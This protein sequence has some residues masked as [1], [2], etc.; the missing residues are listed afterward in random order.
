MSAAL[1]QVVPRRDFS[2][3]VLGQ[4]GR[5]FSEARTGEHNGLRI[6]LGGA[7]NVV[8][9]G[10]L[11]QGEEGI[12]RAYGLEW[13]Q[14]QVRYQLEGWTDEALAYCKSALASRY[15]SFGACCHKMELEARE[16]A[17]V[18]RGPTQWIL[19]LQE[20]RQSIQTFVQQELGLQAAVEL[21]EN[22][23]EEEAFEQQRRMQLEKACQ[24]AAQQVPAQPALGTPKAP[25]REKAPR[26]FERRKPE[27]TV[28]KPKNSEQKV[29][30]GK[31][32]ERVVIKMAEVNVD[33]GKV[34]VEGEVFYTE[35]KKLNN[36][37]KTI[38]TFDMTD[39]TGS[40]RC[41]KVLPDEEC[42]LLMEAVKKGSYVMVQ[43]V[44]NYSTFE[45]DVVVSPTAVVEAKKKLRQD[46]AEQKRVE[47]HLH[48]CMSTMDGLATAGDLIQTA[49]RWG[50][51]AVA[52]T[53]HGVVQSFPMVGN[54]HCLVPP[55]GRRLDQ[56]PG[57][58]QA[59]HGGHAGM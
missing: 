5:G 57:G 55:P 22:Q 32:V 28:Y 44:A 11:R 59:I 3:S 33:S 24:Q 6:G 12:C 23:G 38:Y 43:G 58:R 42:A 18:L 36:R 54:G 53:D 56:I 40:V 41:V 10:A 30:Y 20:L 16:G 13:V 27:G 37:G 17:L 9:D 50:H 15:P 39:G 45:R 51:K 7:G 52:I 31:A 48:T 47:L 46:A 19:R 4:A 25:A 2:G 26:R 49:A 21:E 8:P 14:L 1:C 35:E 29:L 34:A